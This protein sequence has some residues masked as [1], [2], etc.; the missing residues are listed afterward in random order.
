[1]LVGQ[2][3]GSLFDMRVLVAIRGEVARRLIRTFKET[4]T[5]T[6]A[7][8]VADDAYVI[9]EADSSV[10]LGSSPRECMN[11][12]K[13]IQVNSSK[14]GG[15]GLCCLMTCLVTC[16]DK[17]SS[18]LPFFRLPNPRIVQLSI[19]AMVSCQRA[20]NFVRLSQMLG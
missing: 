11:A 20:M 7:I 1:M 6:V 10:C 4:R 17:V 16:L 19:Q 9:L 13:L 14:L 18:L 5:E 15:D 12:A 8:Y 3:D 2:R